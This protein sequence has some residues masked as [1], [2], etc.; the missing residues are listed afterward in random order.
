ME[1]EKQKKVIIH[2]EFEKHALPKIQEIWERYNKEREKIMREFNAKMK[3]HHLDL[4]KIRDKYD[5][6]KLDKELE[7]SLESTD[8]IK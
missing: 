1:K 8:L 2:K 3:Q 4:I 7:K 5:K 6:K